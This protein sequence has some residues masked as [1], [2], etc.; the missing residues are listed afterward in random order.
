VPEAGGRQVQRRELPAVTRSATIAVEPRSRTSDHSSSATTDEAS[1]PSDGAAADLRFDRPA[2]KGAAKTLSQVLGE[3]VWLMSQSPL[4]KMMLISD[5]DWYVMTPAL[6]QQFRLYY[7]SGDS[8]QG[9]KPIGVVLW[10][11]VDGEVAARLA[12]DR[13]RL[14]PQDWKS[15]ERVPPNERQLWVVDVIAPFGGAEDMVRE[16]K[17]KVFPGKVV[18]FVVSTGDSKEIRSM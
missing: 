13:P 2:P 12:S 7:D 5:L 1:R 14:R 6:L 3:V 4:H 10:A 16:L 8:K 11:E 17:Q 15:G 9:P 18:N